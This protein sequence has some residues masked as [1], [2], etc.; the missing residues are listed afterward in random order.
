MV[1]KPALRT[2]TLLGGALTHWLPLAEFL[3]LL[4]GH[5][6][7]GHWQVDAI[8]EW[9]DFELLVVVATGAFEK[10]HAALVG[11]LLGA[12]LVENVITHLTA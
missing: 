6:L 8:P 9:V 5:I 3:V 4:P 7:A 12:H 2:E 10:P 11:R 1:D